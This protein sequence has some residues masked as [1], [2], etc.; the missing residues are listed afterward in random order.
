MLCALIRNRN[1]TLSRER[2]LSMVWGYDFMGETR[3]VDLHVQRV[4]KKLGWEDHIKTVF[5][6]GYKLEV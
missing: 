3:T 2:L 4:R 6:I 5:R 1:I